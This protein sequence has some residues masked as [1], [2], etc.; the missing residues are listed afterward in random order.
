M[1]ID[2]DASRAPEEIVDTNIKDVVSHTLG[3]GLKD[4]IYDPLIPKDH[5]IPHK[6]VRRGYTTAQDNQTSIYVPVYQG[7]NPKA[8]LNYLLGD[9]VIDDLAPGPKGTHQFQV[10]F[11]LDAD[12][13]FFGEL[14][15]QQT[16]Q[17]TPI[18][19]SRGQGEMTEKKRIALADIV[20]SGMIGPEANAPWAVDPARPAAQAADPVVQMIEEANRQLPNLPADRQRELSDL[21]GRLHEA[22]ATNDNRAVAVLVAQLTMLLVTNR[23]S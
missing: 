9:V 22:R 17:V 4:D 23:G 11:A 13:I 1:R 21:L 10:T 20:E 2:A 3:I 19:L 6:V 16:G 14:H 8:S 5:V 18:K 7:D 12:G 15:H